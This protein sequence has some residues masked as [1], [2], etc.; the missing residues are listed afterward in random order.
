MKLAAYSLALT[1]WTTISIAQDTTKT[2]THPIQFSII[3]PLST[4]GAANE[5]NI[6]TLSFNLLA[7]YSGG[8]EGL[9]MGGFANIVKN[10]VNGAQMSGFANIVGGRTQGLQMAGFANV[11]QK[12]VEGIQMA[13]FTNVVS[14]SIKAIQLAGFS[15]IVSGSIQGVQAAGFMNLANEG[16]IGPQIAGFLNMSRG[17]IKGSQI[18]GFYNLSVDTIDGAQFAGFMNIAAKRMQG[19]QISGFLNLANSL[20]GVQLGVINIAD[21][22]ENGTPLGFLSFIR[23]GG[24]MALELTGDETFYAG[25]QFKTG[26]NFFYNILNIAGRPGTTAYWGFGYGIGSNLK[27]HGKLRI[28]LDL[29]ATQVNRNEF[30]TNHLNLLSR[31]KLG[32]T[33]QAS[34]HF[35]VSAGPTFNVLTMNKSNSEGIANLKTVAPYSVYDEIH[36]NNTRLI[37]WPGAHLSLRF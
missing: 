4:N 10:D 9:E 29:T 11:N 36:S 35:A 34:K 37:M 26:S 12:S 14:D 7:G 17:Q 32:F 21:T 6:N 30:W 28:N 33:W 22:L 5:N 20:S 31:A 19:A 25:L 27:A 13:G 2:I 23:K 15:N 16:V 1:L 3:P 8:I 24:F 18:S